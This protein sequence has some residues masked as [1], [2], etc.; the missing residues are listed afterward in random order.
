MRNLEQ[1]QETFTSFSFQPKQTQIV[2]SSDKNKIILSGILEVAS[3]VELLQQLVYMQ[4]TFSDCKYWG[5]IQSKGKRFFQ[6]ELDYCKRTIDKAFEFL[7]ELGVIEIR[8]N[9]KKK[10]VI[11]VDPQ[12]LKD[13]FFMAELKR[14]NSL[15]QNRDCPSAKKRKDVRQKK[16]QKRAE[17]RKSIQQSSQESS[18]ININNKVFKKNQEEE[19]IRKYI[20]GEK[21]TDFKRL[22]ER[23]RQKEKK[24]GQA[25]L[26]NNLDGCPALDP[27]Q[28]K[29]R[30]LVWEAKQETNCGIAAPCQT[31]IESK[32]DPT[33]GS[34]ALQEHELKMQ[35]LVAEAKAWQAQ[36]PVNVEWQ[37]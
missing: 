7:E 25:S 20:S 4:T 8:R 27:Y 14:L 19:S 28:Q 23:P 3:A 1:S 22:G 26:G 30:Q 35:R 9:G 15:A 6:N 11:R 31:I 36:Q 12:V 16:R 2:T 10:F 5:F 17:V 33:K 13:P 29:M 34:E 24:I 37:L 18:L 32:K 21:M